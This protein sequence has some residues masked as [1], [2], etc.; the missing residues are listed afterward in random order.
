MKRE[1]EVDRNRSGGEDDAYITAE[2]GMSQR[3]NLQT[4]RHQTDNSLNY[5]EEPKMPINQPSNQIKFTNVS[6]VRLKKG[7]RP[8]IISHHC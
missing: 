4:E 8:Y 7:R 6:V 2:S 5:E 3:I 1:E